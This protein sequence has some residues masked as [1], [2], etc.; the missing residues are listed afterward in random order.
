VID[1]PKSLSVIKGIAETAEQDAGAIRDRDSLFL[2]S[3]IRFAGRSET[4]RTR[5]R[6][7]SAGGMMIE[8]ELEIG[9][10]TPLVATLRNVG[11]VPGRVAWRR[12]GR[13]GIAFE[14]RIDPKAARRSLG[15]GEQSPRYTKT[16]L[17]IR[18]LGN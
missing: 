4:L 1:D 5:V 14:R 10:G 16:A 12:D 18:R 8:A 9:I 15:K 13:I 11:S 3:E 6:N 7:L 17:G 2:M